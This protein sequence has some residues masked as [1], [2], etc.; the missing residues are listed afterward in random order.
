MFYGN[1]IPGMVSYLTC[2]QPLL[3]L[4]CSLVLLCLQP[5][6]LSNRL[7]E[8]QIETVLMLLK[9][10]DVETQHSARIGQAAPHLRYVNSTCEQFAGIR[11]ALAHNA[12]SAKSKS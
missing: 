4:V 12:W 2:S 9:P 7:Q 6:P 8:S 5:F 10:L 3:F 1:G 11:R